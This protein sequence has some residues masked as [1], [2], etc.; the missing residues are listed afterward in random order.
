MSVQSI[1]FARLAWLLAL[2]ALPLNGAAAEIV[3][4]VSGVTAANGEIGCALFERDI[5]FPMDNTS[6]RVRWQAAAAE[7][8][9]CRF[10][11]VVPGRYAVSVVHD[12]N[13]NRRVDTN[14]IGLPTEAWGVSNGVRPTLRAPRFDEAA[15]VVKDNDG[16]TVLDV[17]VT[18]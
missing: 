6:A 12:L 8:V 16:E 1:P 14:L 3:V 4:R 5:G 2:S 17:A 11:D 13:G 9:T 10:A 7:G 18:R 15:F